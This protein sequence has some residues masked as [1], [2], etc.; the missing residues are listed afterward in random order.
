MKNK[1]PHPLA[2]A[3][4]MKLPLFKPQGGQVFP[5][6]LNCVL[7]AL[8]RECPEVLRDLKQAAQ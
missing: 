5:H 8:M 6:P 3:L 1:Q 7:Q 2:T 4:P